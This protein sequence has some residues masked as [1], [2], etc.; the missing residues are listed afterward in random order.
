MLEIGRAHQRAS[1]SL[2]VA[3][4]PQGA[5]PCVGCLAA[6]RRY[7]PEQMHGRFDGD[8]RLDGQ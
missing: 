6:A 5:E 7:E 1:C 8:N 3:L 4:V 2:P